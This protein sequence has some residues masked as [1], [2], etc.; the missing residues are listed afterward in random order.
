MPKKMGQGE[1]INRQEYKKKVRVAAQQPKARKNKE[2]PS[3]TAGTG[4]KR[5]IGAEEKLQLSD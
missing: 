3:N 5:D 4:K 2:G 1:P